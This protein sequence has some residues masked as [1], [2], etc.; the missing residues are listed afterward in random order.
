MKNSLYARINMLSGKI[1]RYNQE[2]IDKRKIISNLYSLSEKVYLSEKEASEDLWDKSDRYDR[3]S[4]ANSKRIVSLSTGLS[5]NLS[6]IASEVETTFND[7]KK[8]ISD[9]IEECEN[10]IAVCQK[11]IALCKDEIC[12]CKQQIINI[13][14][15]EEKER[16]KI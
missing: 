9:K 14:L 11:E 4:L 1:E 10:D 12:V 2:I 15:Q 6:G 3:M 16:E 7:M 8:A 5:S 13:E